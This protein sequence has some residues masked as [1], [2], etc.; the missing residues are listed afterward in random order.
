MMTDG[1]RELAALEACM[2][3]LVPLDHA[4][5]HRLL[6]Y[7]A[8]RLA[9][10]PTPPE[11]PPFRRVE[12][13]YPGVP[14][15]PLGIEVDLVHVR[16]ARSIRVG[17]DFGRDGFTIT[18]PSDPGDDDDVTWAEVAFVPAWHEAEGGEPR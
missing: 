10:T 1:S 13:W 18:A 14:G 2:W 7:L 11:P 9:A 15:N 4:A 5:R 16:A 17:Y 6:D 8:Q 12:L 3:A